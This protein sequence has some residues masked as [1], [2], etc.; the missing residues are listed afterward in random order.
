MRSSI[1]TRFV[2][3]DEARS[4]ETE[5]SSHQ[6]ARGYRRSLALLTAALVSMV[7]FASV[8]PAT[9]QTPRL[10][11]L[12][13]SVLELGNE[14]AESLGFWPVRSEKADGVAAF[15]AQP[16]LMMQHSTVVPL[17]APPQEILSEPSNETSF[18]EWQT[19]NGVSY[20]PVEG[21]TVT[22]SS[23]PDVTFS[24][25]TCTTDASGTCAVTITSRVPGKYPIRAQVDG[26]DLPNSPN[27]VTFTPAT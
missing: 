5:R 1:F 11:S 3:N 6:G 12:E 15:I 8:T 4:C 21:V 23:T 18:N 27:W 19:V 16:N 22:F 20:Q 17:P 14:S 25:S 7:T 10:E 24:A 9:A 2:R 26:R 13:H